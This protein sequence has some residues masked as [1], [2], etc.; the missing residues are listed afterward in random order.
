MKRNLSIL[1]VVM[2]VLGLALG[3]AQTATGSEQTTESTGSETAV[4]VEGEAAEPAN[5]VL[6]LTLNTVG[7]SMD[8][9]NS[10]LLIDLQV[11]Y[12][13]YEGLLNCDEDAKIS[14]RLA[15]SYTVSEDGTT[16][17]FK[18]R[19]DVFFHN[20][21]KMTAD[22]V[23]W[24]Y[25]R[26][27][28]CAQMATYVAAIDHVEKIDED[29]VNIV[30]K[31]PYA[32]FVYY[33]SMIKILSQK[34][35]EEAGD[36]Y[37]TI[38]CPAGTGP[39]MMEEY[40]PNTKIVL[41]AFDNYYRGVPQIKTINYYV[42]TDA[43]TALIAFENGD[44]DLASIPTANWT[45]IEESGLY[46]TD[47]IASTS[48]IYLALNVGQDGPLGNKLV[49]QAIQY[50]IDK[51]SLILIALDGMGVS[52][53]HMNTVGRFDGAVETDW[54]Y[55]YNPEK[56]KELLTQAGYPDG[57]YIGSIES[58]KYKVVAEALQAQLAQV[59]ITCDLEIGETST[60][61]VDWRAGNYDM[62]C[63]IYPVVFTY[64]FYRKYNDYTIE[65]VFMKYD[66]NTETD[67]VY[68][69]EMFDEAAAELDDSKR[70]ALYK[71]LEEYLMDAAAWVPLYNAELPY[72]WNSDLNA[73]A[74]VQ[75]YEVFDWSWK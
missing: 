16:Y 60:L 2:M 55:E 41:K 74:Y 4:S 14:G 29:T 34:A 69:K 7:N 27:M 59:G 48:T 11:E 15:E 5:D 22:D 38:A 23:V 33:C 36:L 3:C 9:H 46:T 64:D 30:L 57:V 42:I 12:Q 18:L 26:A 62:I 10:G 32:P 35:V 25:N 44:L 65:T 53:E 31:Y 1:L 58:A 73:Y 24:S 13:M 66:H 37:G 63:N 50:A 61:V 39:Y 20:G 45:E 40:D 6:N 75:Y 72:A 28:G 70:A 56:A 8:P 21:E 68:I 49:R 67:E 71:E 17:S 19:Q 43:S 47:V 51:E 52:A 54:N